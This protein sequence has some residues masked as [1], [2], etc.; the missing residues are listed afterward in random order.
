MYNLLQDKVNTKTL[1]CV[2]QK[3][4]HINIKIRHNLLCIEETT[5]YRYHTP[6]KEHGLD[7]QT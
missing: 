6:P 3:N 4:V 1:L 2:F 7:L 5:V